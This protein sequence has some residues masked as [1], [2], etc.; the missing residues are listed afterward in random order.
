[1]TFADDTAVELA[2]GVAVTP[3]ADPEGVYTVEIDSARFEASLPAKAIGTRYK[4]RKTPWS[5]SVSRRMVRDGAAF[6]VDGR[7]VGRRGASWMIDAELTRGDRA[8]VTRSAACSSLRGL[9]DAKDVV[10]VGGMLS[11]SRDD[12]GG[13]GGQL[14]YV[15]AGKPVFW[16]TG[17]RAGQ[18]RS[19]IDVGL[20]AKTVGGFECMPAPLTHHEGDDGRLTVC[21][22]S[23]DVEV[24]EPQAAM[25]NAKI[26]SSPSDRVAKVVKANA[27]AIRECY[28]SELARDPKLGGGKVVVKFVIAPDGK[29]TSSAVESTTL[30][31][32]PVKD[33]I[34]AQV[35][36][37]KFPAVDGETKPTTVR[38]PFNF[39]KQ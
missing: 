19:R 14:R 39:S 23:K 38:F 15:S 18:L 5:R 29:V 16:Q 31:S 22:R 26:D 37:W 36:R 35:R 7:T 10:D 28:R 32:R 9:V 33:C 4:L 8:L 6:S 17:K 11:G 3:V 34:I 13:I 12:G 24:D 2:A 21:F 1:V 20:D 25:I 30:S 27:R